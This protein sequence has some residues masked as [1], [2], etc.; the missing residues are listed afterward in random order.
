MH[1]VWGVNMHC[2]Q[3]DNCDCNAVGGCVMKS[4]VHGECLKALFNNVSTLKK[5]IELHVPICYQCL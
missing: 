5:N 3:C 4:R 1:Y 2:R